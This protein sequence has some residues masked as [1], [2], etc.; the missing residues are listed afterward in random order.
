MIGKRILSPPLGL[1]TVAALLPETWDIH[2]RD[3][4]G[5]DISDEDWRS[6]DVVMISG[7]VTQYTG[8]IELIRESK[9][10]G[11]SVV[12]GGPMAFHIP[13][14]LLE[15]GADIVIRGELE[16]GV[17]MLVEAL[18]CGRSGIIIEM[19]PRPDLKH[20]VPPRYDL[21]GPRYL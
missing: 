16:D 3:L 13:Q 11:K 1:L 2:I 19:P 15:F 21:V 10:H 9:R 6:C 5:Q 4:P 8:I 20:C 7:M 17:Q 18:V 14:D 12:V